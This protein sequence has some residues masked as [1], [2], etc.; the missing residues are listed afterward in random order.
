MSSFNNTPG[1]TKSDQ[2]Q[3][4][5]LPGSSLVQMNSNDRSEEAKEVIQ[6]RKCAK[7]KL[8]SSD[9][10]SSSSSSDPIKTPSPSSEDIKSQKRSKSSSPLQSSGKKSKFLTS[11]G[12]SMSNEEDNKSGK[13]TYSDPAIIEMM[14]EASSFKNES[15]TD[16]ASSCLPISSCISAYAS[17]PEQE[18]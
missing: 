15:L 11:Y 6:P 10:S 8:P 1:H 3:F 7:E 12:S 14:S 16:K 5:D 4:C 9:S 17:D 18:Q 13:H 2:N